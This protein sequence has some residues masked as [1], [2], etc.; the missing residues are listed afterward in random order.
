[1]SGTLLCT[2]VP[3]DVPYIITV[4][5]GDVG[6]GG[7]DHSLYWGTQVSK[8]SGEVGLMEVIILKM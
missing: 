5:S 3:S 7:K 6:K 4:F 1:M 2:V 8:T